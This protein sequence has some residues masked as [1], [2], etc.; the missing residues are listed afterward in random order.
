MSTPSTV[1]VA[2]YDPATGL[3]NGAEWFGATVDL[4]A[5]T[6]AG[7]AAFDLE[8]QRIDWMSQRVDG[9]SL[10]DYQPPAPADDASRTWSWDA[11]SRRWVASS[12]LAARRAQVFDQVNSIRTARL[13]A[14]CTFAGHRYDS[15]PQSVANVTATVAAVA[16]GIALP[17]GFTWRT[18]D[19]VDV[20]MTASDLVQLGGALLAYGDA[21][22][23]ASW[24]LKAAVAASDAPETIDLTVGWPT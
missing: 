7:M 12:T 4:A 24:A 5:N 16:A 9:D 17:A 19:N 10:V 6:P 3:F 20:P 22:Y 13:A 15:D 18:A 14:G 23:R 2:F 8:G 21:V 1:R 11:A